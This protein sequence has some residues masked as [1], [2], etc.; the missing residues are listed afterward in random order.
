MSEKNKAVVRRTA[1]VWNEGD[2]SA[3]DEVYA[4]D[5]ILHSSVAG[6]RIGVEAVKRAIRVQRAAFPDLKIAIE[7]LVAEGD[8]VVNHVSMTGTHVGEFAGIPPSGKPWAATAISVLRVADGKIAEI[9][10]VTDQL[11]VLRGVGTSP[12]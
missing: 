5:V 4:A 2:L 3:A 10:G 8:T 9:W 6:E 12:S 7:H 11:D 1:K